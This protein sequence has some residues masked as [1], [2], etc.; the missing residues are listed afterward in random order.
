VRLPGEAATSASSSS[1]AYSVPAS[2]PVT[3][4]PF[5]VGAALS[6]PLSCV[7]ALLSLS[8]PTNP[9]KLAL[10]LPFFLPRP[11]LGFAGGV[12]MGGGE[13]DAESRM[14]RAEIIDSNDSSHGKANSLRKKGCAERF[15][16]GDGD[17]FVCGVELLEPGDS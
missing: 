9:A 15:S 16:V 17:P 12:G 10:L 7:K 1:S 11:L 6:S 13:G 4:L 3:M 14:R 8:P 5:G 2:V